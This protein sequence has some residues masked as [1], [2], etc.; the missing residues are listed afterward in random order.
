MPPDD[1][2]VIYPFLIQHTQYQYK[3]N[4]EVIETNTDYE[5][6][7]DTSKYN[8]DDPDVIEF[9]V[10]DPILNKEMGREREFYLKRTN[11]FTNTRVDNKLFD[12]NQFFTDFIKNDVEEFMEE[13][14]TK[15]E[16]PQWRAWVI[17]GN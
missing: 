11:V 3:I 6:D 5:L 14:L 2:Q 13:V 7:V 17:D 9:E 10:M 8:M 15:E 12:V 16:W 1:E 4:I